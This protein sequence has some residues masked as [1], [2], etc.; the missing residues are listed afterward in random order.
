MTNKIHPL[1]QD[2][3]DSHVKP[4]A[5][6]DESPDTTVCPECAGLG[7]YTGHLNRQ[8]WFKC[9]S[10]RIDF[11]VPHEIDSDKQEI[12]DLLN[13]LRIWFSR[14]FT[15]N[16]FHAVIDACKRTQL[17]TGHGNPYAVSQV[18]TWTDVGSRTA[19]LA[20]LI[21]ALEEAR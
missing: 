7:I 11:G 18:S 1:F 10:C 12:Q 5:E 8:D 3:L 21:E 15:I 2:I 4:V 19:V 9:S 20:D 6:S 17:L 13:N 14:G 16:E